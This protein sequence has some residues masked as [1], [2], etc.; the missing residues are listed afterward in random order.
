MLG[1]RHEMFGYRDDLLGS[2]LERVT[3][4]LILIHSISSDFIQLHVILFLFYL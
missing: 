3:S 2:R 1:Y 4:E